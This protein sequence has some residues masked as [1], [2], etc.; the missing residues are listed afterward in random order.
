MKRFALF[1]LIAISL[2]IVPH[3]IP[4]ARGAQ[5]FVIKM[6]TLASAG[7]PWMQIFDELNADVM[8]K[9]DKNVRFKVYPGGILG[10][11]KIILKKMYFGQIQ[12]AVLTASSLTA[13]F[14]EMDVLQVPLLFQDY[15]EV[16]YVTLKM[17]PFFKKGLEEKGYVLL[18]W[19][20]GG[21]VRLMSMSPIATLEDL[22][23]AK[24][25]IWE[26]APMAHAIFK[27]ADVAAI[28]LS[29]PDVLVGLQT[30]MVNVVYAPPAGAVDL[31]WFT[32]IK[33]ITD[34]PLIFLTGGIVVKKDLFDRL[35]TDYKRVLAESFKVHMVKLRQMVRSE[36]REALKVMAK[37]GIKIVEVSDEQ[38]E[39]FKRL[40]E[41]AVRQPGSRSFSD[42]VL[43]RL[44][45]YL[46]EYRSRDKP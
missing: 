37:Y 42:A 46:Q 22:K 36:N 7:S 1:T 32:K 39:A 10:D 6:S 4:P 17:G 14:K 9:T 30:G 3:L 15:D 31:Q 43:N 13:I 33:Y 11:E 35:P 38:R 23:R 29:V 44:S 25:W 27:E 34:V 16:D 45:G 24:V 8:Q 26:V 12:G 5:K 19:S 2:L 40:S 28:P 41:K 18:G 20:E 21:F